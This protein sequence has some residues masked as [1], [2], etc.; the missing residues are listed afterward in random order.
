[1][2]LGKNI[3]IKTKKYNSFFK[4]LYMKKFDITFSK[5]D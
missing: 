5:N 1:M 3:Y 2:I 4:N